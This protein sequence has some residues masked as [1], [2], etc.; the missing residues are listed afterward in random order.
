MSIKRSVLLS[1]LKLT[2]MGP[3]Q[4]ELV[5]KDARIPSQIVNEMLDGMSAEGLVQCRGDVIEAS[6]EQ[7]IQMAAHAIRLGADLEGVCKALTWTEFEEV[8]TA[9]FRSNNFSARRG[10]RFRWAGRRWEIDVLGCREPLVVSVDCKHWRRGWRRSTIM[11]V[12]ELQLERTR[13]LADALPFLRE[14]V[15]LIGWERASLIPVVLSLVPGPMKFHKNVPIV[16]ILQLQ[17]FLS[18]LPAYANS[19]KHFT[20]TFG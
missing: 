1:I 14:G 17:N 4:R 19:L 2:R 20:C 8:A 16:P 13:I 15:G 18:E 7:R 9:A 11:R 3:I 6:P 12:V 10:F 5:G